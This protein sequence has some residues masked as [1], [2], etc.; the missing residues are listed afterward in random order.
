MSG[1][2]LCD[3]RHPV[4]H[5]D[6]DGERVLAGS[7]AGLKAGLQSAVQCHLGLNNLLSITVMETI[8]Q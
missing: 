7:R 5:L 4:S 2:R 1:C 8:A 3:P 6:C